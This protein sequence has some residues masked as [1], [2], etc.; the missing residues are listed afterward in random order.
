M[1]ENH[2][3]GNL[4]QHAYEIFIYFVSGSVS[5]S[6]IWHL[7]LKNLVPSEVE[8]VLLLISFS[9]LIDLIILL[10]H[11]SYK[12]KE[13]FT[14][15]NQLDYTDFFLMHF[16]LFNVFIVTSHTNCM[17]TSM[18]RKILSSKQLNSVPVHLNLWE[19]NFIVLHFLHFY[20]MYAN[21]AAILW[22]FTVCIM[23]TDMN[24]VEQFYLYTFW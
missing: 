12:V 11:L 5:P 20:S 13:F 19:N 17:Q 1:W 18:D 4:L 7:D 2:H 9:G 23:K 6:F 8:F 3:K 24:R 15:L 16:Q 22:S 14:G 21:V 10:N